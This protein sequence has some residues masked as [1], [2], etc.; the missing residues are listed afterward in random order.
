MKPR[1]CNLHRR[2]EMN[3]SYYA[4]TLGTTTVFGLKKYKQLNLIQLFGNSV[5]YRIYKRQNK[6]AYGISTF[7][8]C[9]NWHDPT[10]SKLA[11]AKVSAWN[12]GGD[13]VGVSIH[14]RLTQVYG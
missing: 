5:N 3:Y 6:E 8:M 14:G 1:P 12:S 7:I 10:R 13:G 2:V 4:R 9:R 11:N